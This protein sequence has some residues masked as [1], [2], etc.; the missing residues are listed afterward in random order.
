MENSDGACCFSDEAYP[1]KT[2]LVILRKGMMKLLI[3]CLIICLMPLQAFCEDE[4]LI[5]LIP[6]ENI[7]HQMDRYR[8]LAAYLS[9]K[10]GIPVRITILSRYGDII[11]RFNERKLDG[12]FFEIFTGVLAMDKLQVEPVARPV[13]LNGKATEQSYLFVRKDSGIKTVADM[14]GKRI[15]FV[16]RATVT[17]Y[18][19]AVAYLRERGVKDIYRYFREHSFAGS[20]GSVI[21]SVL[22]YRADIGVASSKIYNMLV[23]KD[24]VIGNELAVIARSGELPDV[25]LCLRKSLP[26]D[27]Q[28]RIRDILLNM[29]K[30]TKG[31]GVLRK[32]EALKFIPADKKDY[33]VFF[34][35]AKRANINIKNYRYK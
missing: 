31:S 27:T 2:E 1:M 13:N 16:D 28:T 23:E 22:D 19:F 5:G 4:I 6:E 24:P 7:F 3:M 9:E 30:D 32:F 10:L 14:K 26:A 12:A 11:D 17:G 18:L 33:Q 20:H 34:E 15:T 29:D 25:T 21:Y 35:L 8:P